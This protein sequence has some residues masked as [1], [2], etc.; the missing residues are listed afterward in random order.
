MFLIFGSLF[1][2]TTLAAATCTLPGKGTNQ[3]F[4]IPHWW[5]YLNGEPD[6][7]GKC[8]PKVDFPGG[9]LPV[10]LAIVDM[11]LFVAGIAAVISIIVAGFQYMSSMGNA[12][13]GVSARKRIV[14]SIIGLA[15]VLIAT[16][17]VNFIG[18]TIK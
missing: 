14:N 5:Q 7:F 4:G 15:I 6:I 2:I 9:I 12:E 17:L 1:K 16:T 8:S 10:G 13:K 18:S 11:L 3:F